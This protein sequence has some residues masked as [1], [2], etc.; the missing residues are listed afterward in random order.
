MLPG[1]RFKPRRVGRSAEQPTS[2]AK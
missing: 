1:A 2:A